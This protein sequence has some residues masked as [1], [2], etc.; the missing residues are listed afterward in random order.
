[1][2]W[3]QDKD[4][5]LIDNLNTENMKLVDI[6]EGKRLR[7]LKLKLMNLELTVRTGT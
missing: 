4:Q 1:M 2:Q 3:V 5:R 6:S 7:I